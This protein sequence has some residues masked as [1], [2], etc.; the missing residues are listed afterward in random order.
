M[1]TYINQVLQKEFGET[2]LT[3]RIKQ[4]TLLQSC[5]L[6]KYFDIQHWKW[7]WTHLNWIPI[8]MTIWCQLCPILGHGMSWG[9]EY[10]TR[11]EF[12]QDMTWMSRMLKEK[13]DEIK[14][15]KE[16]FQQYCNEKDQYRLVLIPENEDEKFLMIQTMAPYREIVEKF[17]CIW[18]FLK[19]RLPSFSTE[20]VKQTYA[21]TAEKR[22]FPLRFTSQLNQ[23]FEPMLR[24]LKETSSTRPHIVSDVNPNLSMIRHKQEEILLL[25]R[26]RVPSRFKFIKDRAIFPEPDVE[27]PKSMCIDSRWVHFE[28]YRNHQINTKP[29]L[30]K[31]NK[32]QR[33]VINGIT[34][35]VVHSLSLANEKEYET[36]HFGSLDD[37]STSKVNHKHGGSHSRSL[38]K[39]KF[40]KPRRHQTYPQETWRQ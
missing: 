27:N 38:S 28:L 1:E 2:I 31:R 35:N 29:L 13:E 17:G 22:G 23:N 4:C 20:D 9:E 7:I 26:F 32:K 30:Q 14:K 37:S 21:K 24:R 15:E 11:P 5:R 12:Y 33:T 3:K 19:L 40:P 34:V 8:P 10:S 16:T 36:R 25:F 18:G 39:Q 6:Q